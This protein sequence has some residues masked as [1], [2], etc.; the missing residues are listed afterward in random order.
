MSEREDILVKYVGDQLAAI[1]NLHE[2]VER[3]LEDADVTNAPQASA[4]LTEIKKVLKTQR[5]VLESHLRE[6]IG[7]GSA[8]IGASVK[9]AVASVAGSLSTLYGKIRTEKVSK[10]LRDDYT[11]L[12]LCS[13]GYTML[14]AT[15][16]ALNSETTA[17]LAAHNLKEITPLVVELN[18]IIPSA[19]VQELRERGLQVTQGAESDALAKSNEAWSA[20]NVKR[21]VHH[22]EVV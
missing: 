5:S 10:M 15:A 8:G 16:R 1:D 22:T 13:L 20:M 2:M 21:H 11:A 6:D 3:Q 12:S 4:V 7:G 14:Y 18:E 9:D 19:V 17:A